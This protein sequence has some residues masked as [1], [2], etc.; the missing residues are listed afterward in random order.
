[1]KRRMSGGVLPAGRGFHAGGDVDRRRARV[2]A[3]A[4]ATLSGS[5]PPARIHGAGAVQPRS[6][7]QSNRRALPPGRVASLR[8][9]WPPAAARPHPRRAAADRPAPETPIGPPDGDAESGAKLRGA[10]RPACRVAALEPQ[11]V[12]RRGDLRRVRGRR[13]GPTR[14]GSAGVARR[15]CR[16]LGGGDE[17]RR[18][19]EEDKP[20]PIRTGADGGV[21]GGGV[22]DAANLDP[23]GHANSVAAACAGSTAP[24]IGRPT[25]IKSAPAASAS[26]GVMVRA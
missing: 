8:R 6:A 22:V 17:A 7:A 19:R 14:P 26:R 4:S 25:T 18:G 5:R 11:R 10:A 15:Q 9:P 13:T 12:Q 16:R 21:D 24:V 23:D 2:A 1:M 20:D 3:I